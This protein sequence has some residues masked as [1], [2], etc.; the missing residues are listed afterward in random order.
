MPLMLQRRAPDERQMA[1]SVLLVV[2]L[3]LL[4]GVDEEAELERTKKQ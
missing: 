1:G 3:L 4:L 2:G